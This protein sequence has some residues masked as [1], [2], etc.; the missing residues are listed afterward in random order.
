MI[1][2]TEEK[3]LLL[4]SAR[5]AIKGHFCNEKTKPPAGGIFDKKQGLFVTLKQRGRL[6]GCCGFPFPLFPL[7]KAVG[8]A[9]RN[10]AFHD[11][12]FPPLEL[13]QLEQITIDVSVLTEPKKL[14]ARDRNRLP[15]MIRIG[16]DGLL[17]RN[18][19]MG[20]LLL[21]VVAEEFG[22]DGERFLEAACRKAGL[23]PS[24]WRESS[25]DVF[26]FQATVISE[27]D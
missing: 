4:E 2:K 12:R 7:G 5:E 10:A 23:P 27:K 1:L 17:L 3:D 6:R 18:G 8:E 24:T 16:T 15:A 14:F 20:G 9:A 13:K 19:S 25:C 26:T 11:P 22:M 21:P